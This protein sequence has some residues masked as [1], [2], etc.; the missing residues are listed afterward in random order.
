MKRT[1]MKNRYRPTGPTTDE[2]EKLRERSGGLCEMQLPGCLGRATDVCHRIKR[3]M[4][5]RKGAARELNNRLSNVIHGCREC[6]GWTH[7]RPEE[8]YDLG[9]ML[10]EG[11]D[12]E[13]EPVTRR[14]EW[15]YLYDDGSWTEAVG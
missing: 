4:G 6:H 5:G 12:P 11:Q 9:L 2:M 7:A 15:V 14:C 8:A 13:N 10:R 3:G 1:R